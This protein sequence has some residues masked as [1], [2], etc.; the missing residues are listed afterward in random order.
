MKII[1]RATGGEHFTAEPT[2]PS[3]TD[4]R[5]MLAIIGEINTPRAYGPLQCVTFKQ[6]LPEYFRL[7]KACKNWRLQYSD[8]L[9][10]V[11]RK[12]IPILEEP[13]GEVLEFLEKHREAELAKDL[14]R[15]EARKKRFSAEVE[16]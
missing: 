3:E 9:R 2:P 5:M 14:A 6:P 15:K 12:L 8:V 16:A 10:D 11:I 7:K 4:E 13:T 1:P